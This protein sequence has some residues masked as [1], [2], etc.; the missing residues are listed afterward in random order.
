[1]AAASF[2]SAQPSFGTKN[3]RLFILGD[4]ISLTI[5]AAGTG[6]D[7]LEMGE[8]TSNTHSIKAE[9]VFPVTEHLSL[10]AAFT[11]VRSDSREGTVCFAC[12]GDEVEAL[13]YPVAGAFESVAYR[14]LPE[15]EVS[16]ALVK[17]Q[18]TSC[19]ANAAPE[20]CAFYEAL[21]GHGEV[22]AD[23]FPDEMPL[24]Q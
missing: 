15:L 4:G 5:V 10:D 24:F 11:H 6:K 2:I 19:D 8:L 17:A 18:F 1:M 9:L 14:P 7:L 3:P 23:R 21:F 16:L 12:H 20:T 22:I 13:D